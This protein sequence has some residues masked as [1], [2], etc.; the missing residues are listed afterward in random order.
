MSADTEFRPCTNCG[1]SAK[2][3]RRTWC[4]PCYLRWFK[5][6][7]PE[8]GPP[9]IKNDSLARWREVP[10]IANTREPTDLD[11]GTAGEHLVCADLLLNGYVAFRTDQSCAY[12]IAVDLGGRLVR[13][14]VK[15]TRALKLLPQRSAPSPSY[16]WHVRRAGKGGRR[17]YADDEFDLLALVALDIRQVAYVPPSLSRQTIHIRQPGSKEGKQFADYPFA[18]ALF[19]I[20]ASA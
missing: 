8:G 15:S 17:L 6:G 4:R 12:D 5:A 10:E 11:V 2:Y 3:L 9:P 20:G 16:Q 7:K 19:E 18:R 13:L 14:Q 1:T